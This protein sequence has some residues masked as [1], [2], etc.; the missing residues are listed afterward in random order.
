MRG[1]D[2]GWGLG[3]TDIE[4]M[5]DAWRNTCVGLAMH[6]WRGGGG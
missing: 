1:N 5:H 6:N 3:N 4:I 2:K